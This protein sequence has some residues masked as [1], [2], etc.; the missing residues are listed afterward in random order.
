MLIRRLFGLDGFRRRYGE[1]LADASD[2]GL[3]CRA[4]EQSKVPDAMESVR[5]D[6]QQETTHELVGIERHDL[7]TPRAIATIVFVAEG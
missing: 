1:Q 2:V 3:A 5:Q 4:R 6:M 7:L